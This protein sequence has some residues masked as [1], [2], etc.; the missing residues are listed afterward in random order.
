MK[1]IDI[2]LIK[3]QREVWQAMNKHRFVVISA[4]RQSGKTTLCLYKVLVKAL[5]NPKW[6]LWWVSPQ[7]SISKIAYRRTLDL[8]Q[9]YEIAYTESKSELF[10]ELFNGARIFFKSGDKEDGLRGE[11]IN[12]LVID[13][14]GVIKRDVWLYALRGTI[15]STEAPVLF[16]GTPKGK[17]L[18]HE[19]F[20]KGQDSLNKDYKSFQ[21][22]SNAS[23]YF[24]NDEWADVQQLPAR[25]FEQEYK[26]HF[27]DD[28]GEV[29]RNIKNCIKGQLQEPIPGTKY[30][31][32][33][34][35]AKTYDYTV[36]IIFNEQGQLVAYDRYNQISWEVQKERII[37]LVNKYK[38]FALVDSTGVGD[39]IL[40]DLEKHIQCEGYKFSNTSKRQ[41][42]ERLS[43]SLET[44]TISFPE[45]P[46]LINEL[47][48]FTFEQSSTG[49]IRYNAPSGMHDDI[50]ISLALANWK[51][52][53]G[54]FEFQTI[55]ANNQHSHIIDS[56][57]PFKQQSNRTSTGFNF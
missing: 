3:W 1:A 18:F 20:V 19:L 31:A 57:N 17:N 47:N 34:D 15:S 26:A 43:I 27:I 37:N 55:T 51:L 14:M 40:E 56:F 48:I 4:G 6:I 30:Y 44:E 2:K 32:G 23:P 45:I 38:A 10:I 36:V 28:G 39:P 5:E 41:L 16:I 24:S 42:I 33:I 25:I 53:E 22:S 13:E 49:T 12:Y 29:F 8:L 21:F 54:V 9:D 46:E 35:L 50:V 52:K 11:T 7:Y